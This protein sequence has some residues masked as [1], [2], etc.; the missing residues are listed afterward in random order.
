MGTAATTSATPRR[1]FNSNNIGINLTA[2]ASA[3]LPLYLL[4]GSIPLGSN[5]D[6]D[7]DG[8]P[9]NDLVVII[10]SFK[11]LF[12]PEKTNLANQATLTSP[13]GTMTSC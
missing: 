2:G 9:D 8:Y 3:V 13:G 6:A 4:G 7:G 5:S 11:R 10:P 1:F 12:F